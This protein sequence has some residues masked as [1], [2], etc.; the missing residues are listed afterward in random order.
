MIRLGDKIKSSQAI[1]WLVGIG[2]IVI[3]G[4]AV[5]TLNLMR[6]QETGLWSRQLDN[7]SMVMAEETSQSFFSAYLVLD[8][9]VDRVR[10]E[11]VSSAAELKTRMA[12]PDI[13]KLLRSQISGLP[14]IDVATIVADNGDVI[15]FSRSYPAPSINLKERDYFQAQLND[16]KLGDFISMPVRNKGNGKW[17]FYLSRRL[18]GIDGQFI[19][20]VLVGISIERIAGF[21]ESIGKN[22]GQGATLG[23]YRRD[24]TQIIRWPNADEFIGIQ[25]VTGA[26]YLSVEK[27]GK[28][29]DIRFAP[30][31]DMGSPAGTQLSATRVLERYP[32]IVSLSVDDDI[33]LANWKRSRNLIVSLAAVSILALLLVTLYLRSILIKREAEM[34]MNLQLR[35]K[36]EDANI[37]K[38]QFLT[39]ISHE[40]R[41]PLNSILGFSQLFGMDENL[42]EETK[43]N[44]M[45]IHRAGEHLLGLVNDL[46]DLS[47]IDSGKLELAPKPMAVSSVIQECCTML[48]MRAL[49][50]GVEIINEGG[51]AKDAVI[52]VDRMRFRQAVIN[53]MSNAIKYNRHGGSVHL[54]TSFNDGKVRFTVTDTGHGIPEEKRMRLFKA[55]DRLGAESGSIEGSG[56]GLVI[57]KRIVE[58]MGGQVGFDSVT[59]QGSTFWM[60]FP[61]YKG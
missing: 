23:L 32:L 41:T 27:D 5:A 55:F 28:L 34:E 51:D 58:T 30:K 44:A 49:E 33:F 3:I 38:N 7:L 14:Q 39:S 13:Y 24:F 26:A 6:S 11:E 54:G 50:A 53:F 10:S 36:A 47:R 18:N 59:G 43:M 8:G 21:Y 42:P 2:V 12:S 56:I 57:T 4:A 16:P 46:L 52:Y 22:I 17:T 37:A 29:N 48:H 1:L 31:T 40:L 25:D 9:I 15:N 61:A 45:E 20:L 60:E 19:G 35:H